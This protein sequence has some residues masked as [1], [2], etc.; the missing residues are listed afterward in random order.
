ML[1]VERV[2]CV[3]GYFDLKE[4]L[5]SWSHCCLW[6]HRPQ[7][8]NHSD[9]S[10]WFGIHGSVLSWFKSYLSSCSFRVKFDKNLFLSYFLL[11]CSPRLCSLSSRPTLRHV[12]YPSQHLFPFPRP[13]PLRWWFWWAPTI[14]LEWLNVWK[15][16]KSRTSVNI[17]CI[18]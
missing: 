7:H 13:P 2:S 9:L 12:H 16:C 14:S 4:I 8:L 3:V 18:C 11:W 1:L 6:H 15:F 17:M 5:S 10:S